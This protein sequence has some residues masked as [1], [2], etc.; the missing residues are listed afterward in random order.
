MKGVE[1]GQAKTLA[2]KLELLVAMKYFALGSVWFR[3][4]DLLTFEGDISNKILKTKKMQLKLKS[5]NVY[6]FSV[7]KDKE[8]VTNHKLEI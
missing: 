3:T 7:Y 8:G 2:I 6:V 1:C 5:P 4:L